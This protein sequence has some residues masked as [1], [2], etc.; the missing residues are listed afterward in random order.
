MATIYQLKVTLKG[1]RPAIWRRFQVRSDISF[2]ELKIPT[3][4]GSLT[5]EE[6][7]YRTPF[8]ST[9]PPTTV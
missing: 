7:S 2:Y 3:L 6:Q 8:H 4:N 1:I 9:S 5:Q